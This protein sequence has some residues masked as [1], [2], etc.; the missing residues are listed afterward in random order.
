MA[1][2]RFWM[3]PQSFEPCD[4]D[5]KTSQPNRCTR[6]GPGAGVGDS[7]AV[8]NHFP[9]LLRRRSSG[10]R[11]A[12]GALKCFDFSERRKSQVRAWMNTESAG[13]PHT[14][15]RLACRY[16]T[17]RCSEM[18]GTPRYPSGL[19]Q[20][21][22]LLKRHF[23]LLPGAASVKATWSP[24]KALVCCSATC[25]ESLDAGKI[26]NERTDKCNGTWMVLSY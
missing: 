1:R 4:S 13:R 22:V 25:A 21:I 16:W 2:T 17:T 7:P 14:L 11:H 9:A 15:P 12:R 3:T 19:E 18:R 10:I 6:R 5:F 23:S 20:G 8:T 24:E 26:V